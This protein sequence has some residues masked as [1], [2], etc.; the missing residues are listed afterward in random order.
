MP[1]PKNRPAKK[2]LRRPPT[3]GTAPK[4]ITP[5]LLTYTKVQNILTF[6]EGEVEVRI[7]CVMPKKGATNPDDPQ[8]L[9]EVL[10]L[11][12]SDSPQDSV[13]SLLSLGLQAGSISTQNSRNL[14]IL[15][16][17]GKNVEIS[18]PVSG[19]NSFSW[20]K[21]KKG[22]VIPPYTTSATTGN[23][24]SFVRAESAIFGFHLQHV[25]GRLRHRTLSD[26]NRVTPP[27]GTNV[28]PPVPPGASLE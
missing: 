18:K 16:A 12:A 26:E 22:T 3:T 6:N 27:G 2:P 21:A 23:H 15:K 17:F 7:T 19:S 13:F 20:V 5:T 24:G 4:S 9:V 11:A 1:S 28:P 14:K 25:G 8:Y 10:N